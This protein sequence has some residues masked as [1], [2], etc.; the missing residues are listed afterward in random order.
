MQP[1]RQSNEAVNGERRPVV[2]IAAGRIGPATCTSRNVT[3]SGVQV[4]ME[5]ASTKQV[6]LRAIAELLTK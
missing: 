5:Q 6:V 1:A 4:C 2:L 3:P